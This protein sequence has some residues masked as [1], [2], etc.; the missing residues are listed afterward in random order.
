M[1]IKFNLPYEKPIHIW[2]TLSE[3]TNRLT[4]KKKYLFH[5]HQFYMYE[6]PVNPD[7]LIIE[8]NK[9]EDWV[10][11]FEFMIFCEAHVEMQPAPSYMNHNI[12]VGFWAR[13]PEEVM[14]TEFL[15]RFGVCK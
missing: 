2:P 14:E 9:N 11:R 3:N 5:V 1:A 8:L 12:K 13:F 4:H 6:E 7:E 15:L 10:K